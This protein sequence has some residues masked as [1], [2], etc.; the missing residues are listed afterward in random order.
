MD[1][2]FFAS[3]EVDDAVKSLKAAWDDI[4]MPD[5]EQKQ[6]IQNL[7]N[8]LRNML[9]KE[10]ET[11]QGRREQIAQDIQAMKVELA[12]TTLILGEK[13]VQH[14]NE[15]Q[16]QEDPQNQTPP[17]LEYRA[18]HQKAEALRKE[19]GARASQRQSKE[20]RLATIFD[21]LYGPG[22]DIQSDQEAVE[23]DAPG[24]LALP[25][26]GRLCERVSAAEV[27]R[28][29][30][31]EQGRKL[32]VELQSLKSELGETKAENDDL[33]MCDLNMCSDDGS[34]KQQSPLD[35]APSYAAIKARDIRIT[36]LRD[37]RTRRIGVL[38]KCAEYICELQRKLKLPEEEQ[39]KLPPAPNG[40]EGEPGSLSQQVLV[41]YSTEFTRLETLKAERIKDL[42]SDARMRLPPLWAQL[43]LS[44][45]EQSRRRALWLSNE[46]TS[47][48]LDTELF[49][50][51]EEER[52]LTLR[53]EESHLIFSLLEKREK[54]LEQRREMRAQSSDSSRLNTKGK[55]AGI[56]LLQE[57]KLRTAVER[58]LPRFNKRLRKLVSEWNASH[59][60]EPLTYDGASIIAMVDD[61]EAE[62]ARV[63][64]E[65]KFRKEQEKAEKAAEKAAA[66]MPPVRP[67]SARGPPVTARPSTAPARALAPKR[68]NL[69]SG[70][71]ATH[72]SN[73][74]V[75]DQNTVV[76]PHSARVTDESRRDEPSPPP[77]PPTDPPP[78]PPNKGPTHSKLSVRTLK[79]LGMD[80]SAVISPR[81]SAASIKSVTGSVVIDKENAIGIVS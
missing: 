76:N 37:E 18:L 8:Q 11:Q 16:Q 55:G 30:A 43:H 51:E 40:D 56:R 60:D 72:K 15:E 33:Q 58:D 12:E 20:T 45:E 24:G 64:E 26:I 32:Y 73:N 31:I 4:G 68:Q 53:I 21:E 65:E 3:A 22:N 48:D 19:R 52:S 38:T 66:K 17:L 69:K 42:L 6:E 2:P 9:K 75:V 1:S 70:S 35:R 27:E 34:S 57:Q 78:P 36:Q 49:E 23:P 29:K 54:I 25:L 5:Q 28:A 81:H 63:K 71:S 47:E 7:Q 13:Q 79:E 46:Q 77:P 14:E 50:V 10:V 61:Q 80:D 39:A 67:Q 41:A 74:T 59:E 44:E 62:D